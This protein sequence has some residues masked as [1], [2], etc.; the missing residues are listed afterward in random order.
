MVAVNDVVVPV[1]LTGLEIALESESALPRARLGGRLVLGKG[2]LTDVVVPGTEKVD[3]LDTG[4][5]AERER[6]LDGR[7]FALD[8]AITKNCRFLVN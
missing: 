3:G 7:H 2:D 6:Q 8:V 1:A 5:N 4:R